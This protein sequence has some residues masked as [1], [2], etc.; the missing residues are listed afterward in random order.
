[1]S[2]YL[3]PLLAFGALIALLSI[4][5]GMDPRRVP[6]PFIG[7]PA[8]AFDLPQLQAP[9]RRLTQE[10]L[11]GRPVL[12]NVWASWCVACRHEHALLTQLATERQIP[13][14]GL[15]YK[16]PRAD[17]L[18]WLEVW[19]NPYV[20]IAADEDGRTGINYGVYGV[21]ETF[22]MDAN[23]IIRY[24]HIGALTEQAITD[25]ILPLLADAVGDRMP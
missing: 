21:P 10:D 22:V 4:G 2:R 11:R 20:V 3:L 7:K 23:G 17:A 15:N 18:R 19:G 1:M 24:K 6:S 13:I 25:R 16:D 12:L 14:Y 8:P 5:L 9:D